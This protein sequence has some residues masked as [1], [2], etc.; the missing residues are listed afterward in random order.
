MSR[1]TLTAI[2]VV[3]AVLLAGIAYLCRA[4]GIGAD[5]ETGQTGYQSI[6]SQLAAAVTSRGMFIT[7]QSAQFSVPSSLAIGGITLS[8][9]TR[10]AS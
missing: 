1:R 8:C 5:A 6:L 4:Y 10:Q 7:S 2:V 9:T 3:L